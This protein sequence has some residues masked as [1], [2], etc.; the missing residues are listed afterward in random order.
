MG[1]YVTFVV[2]DVQMSHFVILQLQRF[3][4]TG[5]L[6]WNSKPS[7]SASPSN[8]PM[9]MPWSTVD[10]PRLVK[11]SAVWALLASTCIHFW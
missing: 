4:T 7:F 9:R 10:M 5:A 2:Y 3:V 1:W 8:R 11:V 6:P